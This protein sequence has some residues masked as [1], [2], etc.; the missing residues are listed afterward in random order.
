MVDPK[1]N[2]VFM[3]G[4]SF[5]N[6]MA[7]THR[8]KQFVDY[9]IDMGCG[10]KILTLE[11]RVSRADENTYKGFY[12][13]V[14]YKN[15]GVI[16]GL[17]ALDILLFP[18]LLCYSFLLLLS[19]KDPARNNR[20]YL[21]NGVD[22]FTF[23]PI[24]LARAVGYKVIVEVVEDNTLIEENLSAKR[25]LA[26]KSSVI[27]E[28]HVSLWADALIVI[29]SYLENKFRPLCRGKIP[30]LLIPVSCEIRDD[31][32]HIR[33]NKTFRFLYAG[34]FGEKEGLDTLIK[35][36]VLFSQ[37]YPESELRLVGKPCDISTLHRLQNFE[38]T[39]YLG[40]LDYEEYLKV[41]QSS[42]VLCV[43]RTGSKYANAGFPYKLSEYLATGLPVICS[44]VSDVSFYLQDKEDALIFEPD[45]YRALFE[46]MEFLFLN[47]EL[48]IQIGS[49]G[50]SKAR[51]Y[52]SPAINGRKFLDFI[53]LR[54]KPLK[55]SP[56]Y[57][58]TTSTSAVNSGDK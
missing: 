3:G 44:N 51:R 6:G 2:I 31:S 9:S 21:Y 4:F 17:R 43:T 5:P 46:S 35:A 15:L 30:V 58:E 54:E 47:P 19:Y 36:F 50:K 16:T 18:L 22:L 10:V 39:K 34:S 49:N 52:F 7:G 53:A 13:S 26:L 48:A 55:A 1:L 8:V 41:L 37:K 40:Y 27:L 12:R 42:D 29:S 45:D 28:N 57:L 20:V 25:A 38:K 23:I 11:S 32:E 24:L 33:E 14:P 56:T